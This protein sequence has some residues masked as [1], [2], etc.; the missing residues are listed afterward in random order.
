MINPGWPEIAAERAADVD[1]AGRRVERADGGPRILGGWRRL[2]VLQD[3]RDESRMLDGLLD[4]IRAGQSRSLV[5]S[6][7]A[8]V[9]KTALLDYLVEQ[10]SDCRVARIAGVQS[11]KQLAFAGLHQLCGPML[12][13]LEVLPE[14]QRNALGVAFGLRS[15]EPPDRFL[16]GLATLSLLAEVAMRQPLV[17]VIDDAQWFDTASLQAVTFAARRMVAERIA[18]VFA[19]RDEPGATLFEGIPELVLMGLEDDDARALLKTVLSGP[20][21]PQV[22]DRI[23]AEARGIPLALLEVPRGLTSSQLASGFGLPGAEILPASVEETYIRA[24]GE[25][26]SES[27]RLLVVAAA[28]PIG[29]PILTW[30]AAESLGIHVAAAGPAEASGLVQF[31]TRI[32]FRHPLVRSAVYRSASPD[33]LRLAHAALAT[34]TDPVADPDR[35][36]WHKSQSVIGPDEAVAVELERSSGR[37]QARGGLAAAAAFMDRAVELTAAAPRRTER[38]IAAARSH[39]QAGQTEDA[40]R[41]L[42]IAEAGRVD[43]RARAEI[44]LL[45]AQVA[46]TVKRGGDAPPLLLRAAR[47][48]EPFDVP[49]ARETYLDAIL[50]AMFAGGFA[51]G[52]TL[53]EAAEAA[54]RAPRPETPGLPSDLLLDGL[55]VRF[56]DGYVAAVPLLT[57]ALAAFRDAELNADSLRWFWLAHITAGNLW[58][59][60]TLDNARH[61]ELARE[62]GAMATLP[63]ALSVRIGAHV[64][65]GDLNEAAAL[66]TELD[67][68]SEA[69]GLPTAPYGAL[70]LA[71]WQGREQRGRQL[72][73][74]AEAEATRRGE[75]FGLTIAGLASAVLSNSLGRYDEAYKAATRAARQPPVMGVE[76][77]GVLVELVEA[78]MRMGDREKA[79]GACERVS[80]TVQATQTSWGLGIE[81]RCN[82][83]RTTGDEADR[84]YRRAIEQLSK[85]RIRGELARSHL[86]YGEWLRREG[87][88]TEARGQLRTAHDLFARM[89]MQAFADRTAVELRAAG[90]SVRTPK[91]ESPGVLTAQE[92]Q[93]ARL[94]TDGLS[95]AEI[96]ARLFISPRTVEWHLSKVFAKLHLTSRRQLRKQQLPISDPY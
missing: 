83:L 47:Q 9:G 79:I 56:T 77:W 59:E 70:L 6:G 92:A 44:D 18:I 33:E 64:L 37:A 72:V 39:E 85:T 1:S 36:A 41:Q 21:D 27:R 90:D 8:G 60:Q 57:E 91:A 73:E 12:G 15:G 2:L 87:R 69:T 84:L 4:A 96:A 42:A 31:G 55:A 43:A 23:V 38:A 78:A 10:A 71:A 67:V 76:P 95:N 7:E 65:A 89:G 34:A 54:K 61:L 53:R 80:E 25:L 68:V 19:V 49:V 30:R 24:L 16:V 13:K 94:V 3:R 52:G 51:D 88:V 26:P 45:R 29:D 63:L 50:A 82:A 86:L 81:A 40:L 62:L 32:Q 28:D 14:P 93:I 5:L 35:R 46:F 17:C 11:E 58:N 22:L 20:A 75:S 74:Q 66:V 48:L